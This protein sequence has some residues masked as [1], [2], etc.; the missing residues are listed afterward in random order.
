MNIRKMAKRCEAAA[1]GCREGKQHPKNKRRAKLFAQAAEQI[2]K[3]GDFNVVVPHWLEQA[4]ASGEEVDITWKHLN[5][6]K[7]L[8]EFAA[9]A[10]DEG[11]TIYHRQLVIRAFNCME[12]LSRRAAKILHDAGVSADD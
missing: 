4:A 12:E 11:L 3:L 9:L 10:D 7:W 2:S 1:E 5:G 8:D 6:G